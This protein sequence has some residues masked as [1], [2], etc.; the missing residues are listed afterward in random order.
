MCLRQAK[1][2]SIEGHPKPSY[3]G[4]YT[5]DSTHEGWPVL[6]N[7]RGVNCYRGTREQLRISCV[8][9]RARQFGGAM[10]GRALGRLMGIE[11]PEALDPEDPGTTVFRGQLEAPVT[12][13]ELA[14]RLSVALDRPPLVIGEGDVTSVAWCTGAGGAEID[15]HPQGA[16]AGGASAT[17]SHGA[18][19]RSECNG[20]RDDPKGR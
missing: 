4:L 12:V 8:G 2:V 16:G 7:E 5:H 6:K 3:N 19:S 9:G 17:A 14:D 1:A 15:K 11:A 10:P 20:C 13:Q 18:T